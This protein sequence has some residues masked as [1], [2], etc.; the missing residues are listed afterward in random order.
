MLRL[1]RATLDSPVSHTAPFGPS[2]APSAIQMGITRPHTLVL[3]NFIDVKIQDCIFYSLAPLFKWSQ[4][5][6][7]TGGIGK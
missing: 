3:K 7:E 1:N 2:F 6:Y 4:R 5:R